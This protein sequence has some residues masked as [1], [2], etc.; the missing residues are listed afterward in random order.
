M[1]K[2]L[3]QNSSQTLG[4]EKEKPQKRRGEKSSRVE[5]QETGARLEQE[6][7]EEKITPVFFRKIKVMK[8]VRV[9]EK[10]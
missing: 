8:M 2:L 5:I 10:M 1:L 6:Q 7:E 4:G 3:S 9:K